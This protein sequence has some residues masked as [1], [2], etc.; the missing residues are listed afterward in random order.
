MHLRV[1]A[2]VLACGAALPVLADGVPFSA[3]RSWQIQRIGSPTISP[4]GKT[5]VAPVTNFDMKE[6]KGLTDLWLWSADGT[7]QRALT[8]NPASDSS[9][10][11]SPDGRVLAFISQRNGDTAPQIYCCRWRAASP[12]ASRTC[13]RAW[14]S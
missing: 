10:L 2:A 3:E 7:M 11:I 14:V 12:R 13:P 8:T 9:P 1:L 5:V 6:N 4:D